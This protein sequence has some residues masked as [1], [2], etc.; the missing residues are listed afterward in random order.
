MN[1][2][3]FI[4]RVAGGYGKNLMATRVARQLRDQHPGARISVQASYPDAFS[5]LD[6][7]DGYYP[8]G[9]PLPDFY[10]RH[11]GHEILDAEPYT[12]LKYRQGECHL[13]DAWCR[14]LGLKVP[15]KKH[16]IIRLTKAEKRAAEMILAQIRQ[17]AQGRPVVGVQWVGGTSFYAPQAALDPL[18]QQQVRELPMETAQA[19][20]NDLVAGGAIPVQVGLPTEARL[21]NC[22]PLLTQEGQAFPIRVV[23][24]CLEL[25]DGLVAVDSFAAHAWAAL[26]KSKAVVVW[27]ATR[28]DALGYADHVNITPA[29]NC[30]PVGGGCNRPDTH[31]GDWVGTGN[32]WQCPHDGA[33]MAGYNG[34]ELAMKVLGI[35]EKKAPA[36]QAVPEVKEVA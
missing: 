10:E 27:G 35:L 28:S 9:Q 17:Q 8:L 5:N 36:C 34:K 23:M 1:Q 21:A 14:K 6:F 25:M 12:D 33:C 26:G 22:I 15:E 31:L 24:A 32:V 7:I 3:S 19:M 2:D 13:V 29:K 16:G 4:L 30:C 20:V 18:R 11:A